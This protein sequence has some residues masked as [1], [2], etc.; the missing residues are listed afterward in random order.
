MMLNVSQAQYQYDALID[1]VDCQNVEDTL[2]CLRSTDI[3]TLQAANINIPYAGHSIP[4][5]Y[6]YAPVIDGDLILD[7]TH[8]MFAQGR[9]I[10]VP[11]VFGYVQHFVLFISLL[12]ASSDDTNEGT[13]FTPTNISTQQDMSQFL[14][15]QFPFLTDAMSEKINNLYP[16]AGQFP[17]HGAYYSA[18]ANAYGELRYICVGRFISTMV[19]SFGVENSWNY[20]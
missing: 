12:T 7:Y 18:A 3:A 11:M 4:P 19:N 13:V 1:R 5:L 20:Q 17:N 2:S 14:G 6:M 9:F 16:I 10:K 15:D 8:R